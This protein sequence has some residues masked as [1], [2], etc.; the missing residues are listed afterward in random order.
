M[1]KH[2]HIVRT[3]R[4]GI[5]VVAPVGEFDISSVEMLRST[6]L[7]ATSETNNKVVVDLSATTFLDS[8]ALGTMLG[9]SRRVNGWGGWVRVAAPQ[10]N[11]RKVLRITG[12]DKV[13][14]LYDTLDQAVAHQE[15]DH[16]QPDQLTGA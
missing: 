2:P 6:F 10:P 8:M 1:F 11:V 16:I 9:V 13:F 4:G 5:V 3:E 7:D 12:L 14:A 15:L